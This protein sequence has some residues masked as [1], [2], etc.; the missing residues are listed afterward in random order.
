LGAVIA[1]N[2]EGRRRNDETNLTH[3]S[4]GR[5]ILVFVHKNTFE[6]RTLGQKFA[7]LGESD[8]II[9]QSGDQ[10]PK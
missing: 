6:E 5:I 3:V 7:G 2:Y 4:G 8:S 1:G 10:L 9:S